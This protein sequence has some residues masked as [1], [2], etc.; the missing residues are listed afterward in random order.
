MKYSELVEVYQNLEATQSNL[1]K[2]SL[3]AQAFSEATEQELQMLVKMCR[4]Q[5]FA[6][7]RT[8]DIGISSKLMVKALSKT[9]GISEEEIED[10]WR[11]TG[12]LGKTAQN[13]VKDK[14]QQTLAQ[15]T[16][17]VEKVHDNLQE[18]AGYEG[19]GSQGRKL[20]KISELLSTA[21]PVEACYIVRTIIGDMRVGVG[22]G[23]IR[24]ALA[25]AFFAEVI[26]P[27]ELEET[28]ISGLRIA[29]QEDLVEEIDEDVF[30]NLADKNDVEEREASEME[31]MELSKEEFDLVVAGEE[32]Y[33]SLKDKAKEAIQRGFD[34]TNDFRK[35]SKAALQGIEGLS[36]LEMELF[37]PV[38]AMLA[39]KVESMEDGFD[40]V[41]DEEGK[42]AMEFKYDGMRVQIHKKGS[43]VKVFTR[44]LE[45]I[46]KQFPDIVEAVED[47]VDAERCI[48][49]GEAVGY[50]PETGDTIPFQNLSKR[51]KRKYDIHTMQEKIPVTVNLFDII[52]LEGENLIDRSLKDRW[53]ALKEIIEEERSRMELAD[54]M[55]TGDMDDAQAFYQ[56]SLNQGQEGVMLKS[57]EAEYQPGSRVGHMV[58]LKPVMETLDLVIVGAEWGEGRRSDWLGSYRLACRDK[59][60][61]EFETV[62][63]MATGF[64]DE[65]LE[66]MTERLNDLVVEQE[67]REVKIKPEVVVEVAYEE[68]QK[69]PK[70]SSGFALR[71]PRLVQV[72]NDIGIEDA[73]S[74][75]K[76]KNLFESQG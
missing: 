8:D 20:D 58:K 44:R 7:W 13:L 6:E 15:R 60:S 49:E 21:E 54:H 18:M 35:V 63:N 62:G 43:E 48:I 64:T 29:V 55:E 25:E 56:K 2:T 14:R 45:D 39:Q 5:V 23:T 75:D 65:Q 57:L 67:G 28:D 59:D 34:V 9:T 74:L 3:L 30:N 36:K 32:T 52:Y 27:G 66:D 4:G 31:E 24:D 68:I 33:E 46:T 61:G 37:R 11:E 71:F 12:D 1:E 53:S 70:Y 72:R 17:T 50:D 26:E 51:I 73:D 10:E 40:E 16:L 19:S 41:S 76:V 38:N 69:S 47:L 42:V 22:E